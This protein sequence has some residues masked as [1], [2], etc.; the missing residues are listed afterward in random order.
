M[1]RERGTSGLCHE[2]E[3]WYGDGYK[4]NIGGT[5]DIED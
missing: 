2:A 1:M 4:T 3:G 5:R